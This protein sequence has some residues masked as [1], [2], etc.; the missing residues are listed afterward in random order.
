VFVPTKLFLTRGVGEHREEL[1]SLEIPGTPEKGYTDCLLA[2]F[3]LM[4]QKMMK[5]EDPRIQFVGIHDFKEPYIFIE[6][7]GMQDIM[8]GFHFAKG[9]FSEMCWKMALKQY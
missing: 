2:H 7:L 9:E 1:Q 4:E 6:P 8:R 3:L 5:H